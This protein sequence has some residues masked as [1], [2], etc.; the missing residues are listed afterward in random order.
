MMSH[1]GEFMLQKQQ[2]F[3]FFLPEKTSH[4]FIITKTKRKN[5][6]KRSKKTRVK[7]ARSFGFLS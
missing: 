5:N 1:Q 7:G 2:K 4:V 6:N 3:S